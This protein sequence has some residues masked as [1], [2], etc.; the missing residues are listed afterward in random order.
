MED[1][2][3]EPSPALP[4]LPTVMIPASDLNIDVDVPIQS[5]ALEFLLRLLLRKLKIDSSTLIYSL[6]HMLTGGRNVQEE[7][8]KINIARR[9][10]VK[11]AFLHA[12]N[13]Y[14]RY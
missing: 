9:E 13:G 6:T 10:A 8:D 11:E 12:W 5:N 4:T 3:T 14:R 1:Q 7:E 2:Q